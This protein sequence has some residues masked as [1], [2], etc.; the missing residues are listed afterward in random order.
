MS[1]LVDTNVIC[2]LTRSK[3][4]PSVTA[5]FEEV[6]DEALHLS[7]LTLGELRRGV[8]KLPS[9][10][11]K[12]KLRNWLEHE[13]PAWLGERLLPIDAAVAD[14]WGRLQATAERTL[15]A[16]D[17]LL[18]ATALRHH[19]RLVTRNTEDFEAAGLE[20]INPWSAGR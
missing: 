10:T 18:A 16:V 13:L 3:P 8:E 6:A 20:T 2:E 7:V 5:W 9:G 12:E 14:T 11:R 4:A 19:L 1:Y 15:P 17:S